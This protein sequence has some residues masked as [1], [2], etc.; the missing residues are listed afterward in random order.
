MLQQLLN[1]KALQSNR[2]SWID[3]AKGIAIILVVYRHVLIGFSRYGLEVDPI[4]MAANE[5]VFTF[6]MPLF[7][8]LSGLFIRKSLSKRGLKGLIGNKLNFLLYPYLLWAAIQ[9]TLQICFSSFTNSSRG[10]IDYLYILVQPRAIDQF[11]FLYA[12]FN[13]TVLYMVLDDRFK[14]PKWSQL[15]LG[16]VFHL[17]SQYVADYSLIRDLLYY[18]IFFGMGDSLSKFILKEKNQPLFVSKKLFAVLGL[19][20]VVSQWY[21]LMNKDSVHFVVLALV[22]VIGCAFMLNVS[23]MIAKTD[24]FKVLRW[25]GFHS[26]YVYIMHVMVTSALRT[27]MVSGF[28]I[29]DTVL[30]LISGIFLGV[31]LPIMFYNWSMKKGMWYLYS[32]RKEQPKRQSVGSA[33]TTANSKLATY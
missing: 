3:Y 20:F 13:V 14:L 24:K 6:R 10:L 2:L 31:L 11:W 9:V 18:Y 27:V 19:L 23:F 26:L 8:V 1:L 22:S 12:L 33:P 32:F 15:A 4:L 5:M 25:V 28:H 29:T 16:A 30:L 7:F 17:L 21:W